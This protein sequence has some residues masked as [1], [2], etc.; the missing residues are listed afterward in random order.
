MPG[1]TRKMSTSDWSERSARTQ[2]VEFER[3]AVAW[4]QYSHRSIPLLLQAPG[5]AAAILRVQGSFVIDIGVRNIKARQRFHAENGTLCTFFLPQEIL[6]R[7]ID[8]TWEEQQAHLLAESCS[9]STAIRI[10]PRDEH[11]HV[12]PAV[13]VESATGERQAYLELPIHEGCLSDRKEVVDITSAM[14]DRLGEVA[15]NKFESAELIRRA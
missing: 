9:P 15:L 7:C 11:C 10:I 13:L 4:Q 14:F 5:Y 1:G 12:H 2:L 8:D 3:S 6:D